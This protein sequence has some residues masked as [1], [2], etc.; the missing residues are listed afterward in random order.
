MNAHWIG[1][2]LSYCSNHIPRYRGCATNIECLYISD[3]RSLVADLGANI[4]DHGKTYRP[5]L[6][7]ALLGEERAPGTVLNEFKWNNDI[8]IEETSGTTGVPF[9]IPKRRVER[10]QAAVEIWRYRKTV[11]PRINAAGFVPFFHQPEGVQLPYHPSK[12]TVDNLSALY[13]YLEGRNTR[14]IH[15]SPFLLARHATVLRTAGLSFPQ[16]RF[17]ELSGSYL[18]DDILNDIRMFPGALIN[19][20][21]CREVWGIGYAF[22]QGAFQVLN[23]HVLVE[24]V[25][26]DGAVIR[27]S[28]I[29]GEI[30]VTSR[31][32]RLFPFI[33]YNTHDEG[34]WVADYVGSRF[35]LVN[36]QR[37]EI[38]VIGG[39]RM[40]GEEFFR[41]MVF[42]AFHEIG[43]PP[44]LCIQIRQTSRTSFAVVTDNPYYS[45]RL[46]NVLETVCRKENAVEAMTFVSHIPTPLEIL[47]LKTAKPRLFV[48]MQ[49]HEM[50]PS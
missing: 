33:R 35:V 6:V 25:G 16:L 41:I 4:S 19:Q 44:I 20:Y 2:L 5:G 38:G 47:S 12:C 49:Q 18:R 15:V 22:R 31:Y 9:R 10:A 23:D 32:Q 1:E 45:D 29:T 8:V 11:D 30:V 34:E 36:N 50:S 13:S 14:W 28:G 37:G 17:A 48:P 7:R 46:A 21:G 3:K 27:E 39:K 42:R 40:S 24:I 26:P 43:F